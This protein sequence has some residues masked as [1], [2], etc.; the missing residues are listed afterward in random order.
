MVVPL[1][2]LYF[3]QVLKSLLAKSKGILINK[4]GSYLQGLLKQIT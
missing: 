4:N 1:P 2:L 3:A